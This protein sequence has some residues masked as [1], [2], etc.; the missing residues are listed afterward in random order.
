VHTVTTT[1][2][3]EPFV[4]GR[5][6]WLF[7]DTGGGANPRAN[8]YS[9][10]ETVKA[11]NIEPYRYLVALLKKLPL[12]QTVD[13]YE[14]LLPWDIELAATWAALRRSVPVLRARAWS[15]AGLQTS[16]GGPAYRGAPCSW[17]RAKANSPA[18][19]GELFQVLNRL[20]RSR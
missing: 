7:A 9:L 1:A 3:N 6:S 12:S 17:R 5:R 15:I 10:F 16:Y 2:A 4:V 19:S 8:L 14:A 20:W 18:E 11:N 13:N